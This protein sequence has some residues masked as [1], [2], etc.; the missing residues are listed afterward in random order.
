MI[1]DN[2][3]TEL[4]SDIERQQKQV[5]NKKDSEKLYKEA[6]K[7]YNSNHIN[8][9]RIIEL[10]ESANKKYP[11]TKYQDFLKNIKSERNTVQAERF[12]ERAK[13]DFENKN[14]EPAISSINE[15]IK[16][17]PSNNMYIDL[18]Q[19]IT[20]EQ[21]KYESDK[22]AEQLYNTGIKAYNNGD[23]TSAVDN[24]T[25]A[26]NEKP[27]NEEWKN[28]LEKAQTGKID[29]TTCTKNALMTLD[30]IDNEKAEQ[31]IKARND[32]NIWYGYEEFAQAFSLQPHQYADIEAKISFPL[33]QGNKYGR[34][35]DI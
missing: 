12:Y 9:E 22:K 16:L 13:K 28:L 27:D 15:A 14:Y 20:W 4:K 7:L 25:K 1:I 8:Y 29:I 33:K 21:R 2:R 10:L 34:R 23:F 32:S 3:Y 17:I 24:L 18:K 19:K 35:L 31:I 30:F 11:K 5:Q 26:C 6:E